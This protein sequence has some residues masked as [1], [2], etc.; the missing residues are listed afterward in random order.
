MASIS[1]VEIQPGFWISVFFDLQLQLCVT[2]LQTLNFIRY[3]LSK[4]DM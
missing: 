1:E 4:Y 3:L 2:Q